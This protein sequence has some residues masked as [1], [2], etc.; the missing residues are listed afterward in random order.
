MLEEVVKVSQTEGPLGVHDI[1][2]SAGVSTHKVEYIEFRQAEK[3]CTAIVRKDKSFVDCS[4][5]SWA[6]MGCF[7]ETSG[8][9]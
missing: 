6:T 9:F 7:Q 4:K 5:H 2:R 3:A 1:M 8:D